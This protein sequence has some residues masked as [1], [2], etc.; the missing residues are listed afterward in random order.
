MAD[1]IQKARDVRCDIMKGIGILLVVYSHNAPAER[2]MVWWKAI[3]SFY[4]PMFFMLSGMF[5]HSAAKRGGRDFCARLGSSILFPYAFFAL[6]G[7]TFVCIA[8]MSGFGTF[9][10]L[11]RWVWSFVDGHPVGCGSLWFLC[12]LGNSQL[13]LWLVLRIQK[14]IRFQKALWI[15]LACVC[16]VLQMKISLLPEEKTCLVPLSLV[17]VPCGFAFLSMGYVLSSVYDEL[18]KV[19]FHWI[20]SLVLALLCLYVLRQFAYVGPRYCFYSGVA[21]SPAVY[22]TALV[23]SFMCFM[24]ATTLQGVRGLNPLG[25][26]LSWIGRNS[27]IF[28]AAESSVVGNLSRIL[29]SELIGQGRS[30]LA[31]GI[32]LVLLPL[33]FWAVVRPYEWLKRKCWRD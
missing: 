1:G 29:A 33:A 6:L 4:M 27:L 19:S 18:R 22:A 9:P 28:F 25:H 12:A 7:T 26:G 31:F 2:Y 32:A 17:S 11:P 30:W 20:E 8:A 15:A 24:V 5:F 21:G 3:E 16:F 13:L 10:S 14:K 23:G